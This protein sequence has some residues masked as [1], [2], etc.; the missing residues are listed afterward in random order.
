MTSILVCVRMLT[1]LSRRAFA[2]GIVTMFAWLG[3]GIGGYQGGYFFDQTGSYTLSYANAAFAGMVNLM[4]IGTLLVAL[5]RR[6]A[7]LAV[8]G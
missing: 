7:A 8:A 1:P 3:H 6:R 2:L 4:L 5:N